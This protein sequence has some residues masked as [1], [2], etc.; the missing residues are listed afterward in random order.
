MCANEC[1]T[2]A[3]SLS[4]QDSSTAYVSK[5]P[6]STN[7]LAYSEDGTYIF[8][9]HAHGLSVIDTTSYTCEGLWKESDVEITSIQS[10]CLGGSV[11]LLSTVDD[12]G[13]FSLV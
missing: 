1:A 4:V 5:V 8:L 3:E 9:G 7:C 6:G 2:L 11:H 13:E 12:M 10:T